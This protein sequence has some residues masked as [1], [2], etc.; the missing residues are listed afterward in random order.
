[1]YDLPR[2]AHRAGATLGKAIDWFQGARAKLR[3]RGY[4]LALAVPLL[5]SLPGA[6]VS[7]Y[8]DFDGNLESSWGAYNN[9]K[10]P[11]FDQDGDLRSFSAAELDAIRE[12]WGRVA[13]D[14]APFNINVTTVDP[15]DFGD[16]HGIHVVIGGHYNDWYRV[17][18]GG[19]SFNNSFTN[20]LPNTVFVF[21]HALSQGSPKYVADLTSHEVGHTFGLEE[22]SV[23]SENGSRLRDYNNGDSKVWGPLMGNSLAAH[24]SIWHLGTSTS[25]R[26]VQDDVAIIAGKHNGFG[27]RP[28]D[29]ADQAQRG[30]TI[31]CRPEGFETA[32]VITTVADHDCFRFEHVGGR[33]DLQVRVADTGPNLD[34]RLELRSATGE[35]LAYDDPDDDLQAR[36]ATD[37]PRGGYIAVVTSHG[38]YGDLGQ[39]KLAAAIEPARD[40]PLAQVSFKKSIEDEMAPAREASIE[41]A[42]GATAPSVEATTAGR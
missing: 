20:H 12:I 8:L 10:T 13:E 14:F 42:S 37:L 34:A 40:V 32:G 21:A 39:Y 41:P 4:L 1:M 17:R 30:T 11:P 25:L 23:Y 3:A 38:S 18:V 7:V 33:L 5:N 28:D 29:H 2:L 35:L 15:R 22:Q 24:R 26:N 19:V 9:I 16:G 27:L 36:I 6:S 31:E